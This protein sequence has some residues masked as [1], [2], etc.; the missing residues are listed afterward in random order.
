[1]RKLIL[2]R[3]SVV[4]KDP[5]IPSHEWSLSVDGRSRC[6]TLIPKLASCQPTVIVTSTENKARETGQILADGLGVPWHTAAN[7]Q[8]HD[9]RDAPYFSSQE[10]FEAAVKRLFQQPDELVLGRETAV[11]ARTRFIQGVESVL[12]DYPKG[13]LAIVGH[14]TVFTLFL[15]AYN[16]YLD[17]IQI[18]HSL[19]LPHLIVTTLQD[20][21]LVETIPY[22][23]SQDSR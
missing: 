9:R 10:A 6:H 8:E 2:I 20:M 23:P 15:C 17:P 22:Q 4:Q 11:Q 12:A 14:G 21:K 5:A 16:P 19:T 3:H 13:N 1:M 7:L 18:W